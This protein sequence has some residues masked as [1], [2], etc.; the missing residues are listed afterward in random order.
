MTVHATVADAVAAQQG[1]GRVLAAGARVVLGGAAL[2]GRA[3]HFAP[4]VVVDVPV[5]CALLREESFAPV[6][7]VVRARDDAEAVDLANDTDF[8]LS[9]SVFSRDAERARRIASR[10]RAGGVV[11]GD[12]M[13]GAAIAALPFGGE[14]VSGVGRLQG[15]DAFRTF[16]RQRSV[17]AD[18][19]PMPA[20]VGLMM[21]G[22]R[23]SGRAL[24]RALALLG[25]SSRR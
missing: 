23:P 9:A 8:G 14:G 16:S 7:C 17:V 12:A 24:V 13:F 5:H 2:P 21:T 11:I 10:L 18:R 4:T 6:V 15:M 20:F 25:R 22:R 3:R 19:V 1:V